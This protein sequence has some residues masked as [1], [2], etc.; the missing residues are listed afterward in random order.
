M[1]KQKEQKGFIIQILEA[2]LYLL[3]VFIFVKYLSAYWCT[4]KHE[5]L[6]SVFEM[7]FVHWMTECEWDLD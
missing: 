6:K 3:F 1:V 7:K 4:T 2:V 5:K